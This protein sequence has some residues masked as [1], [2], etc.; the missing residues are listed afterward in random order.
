MGNFLARGSQ[1]EPLLGWKEW[2]VSI[3]MDAENQK[4]KP[5]NTKADKLK[6]TEVMLHV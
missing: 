2:N 4:E 3:G 5:K 6:Y 1:A